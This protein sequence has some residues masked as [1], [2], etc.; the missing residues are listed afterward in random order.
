MLLP[1]T[2]LGAPAPHRRAFTTYIREAT[3]NHPEERRQP[4]PRPHPSEGEQKYFFLLPFLRGEEKY[5][6]GV[7]RS[8]DSVG[9]PSR[10]QSIQLLHWIFRRVRIRGDYFANFRERDSAT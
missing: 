10:E 7:L 4:N 8:Q 3:K 9:E 6:S 2:E 5:F 1:A